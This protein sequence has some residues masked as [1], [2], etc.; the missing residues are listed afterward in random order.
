MGDPRIGEL[1]R[2]SEMDVPKVE[3]VGGVGHLVERIQM[4][5]PQAR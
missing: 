4:G 1:V 3:K 2:K 5:G